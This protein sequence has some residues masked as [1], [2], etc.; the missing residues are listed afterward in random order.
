MKM[1]WIHLHHTSLRLVRQSS[2][3][4]AF[5]HLAVIATAIVTFSVRCWSCDHHMTCFFHFALQAAEVEKETLDLVKCSQGRNRLLPFLL[6]AH[7][8]SELC[9]SLQGSMRGSA[10]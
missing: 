2:R 8:H 3:R 10:E 7:A 9:V 1:D 5:S 4:F 6:H